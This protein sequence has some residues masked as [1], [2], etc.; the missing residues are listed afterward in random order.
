[1]T[2]ACIATIKGREALLYNTVHS[3]LHQVDELFIMYNYEPRSISWPRKVT[4]VILDNEKGDAAKFYAYCH[5]RELADNW[6]FCDDDLIYPNDYISKSLEFLKEYPNAVL[7]YHARALKKRP[8][9]MFYGSKSRERGYRCLA[10]VKSNHRI[11]PNGTLGTGVMFMKKP[12]VINYDWFMVK[13][14]ADIWLAKFAIEQK[15]EMIVCK[16]NDG[17]IIQQPC[18]GIWDKH[19]N[20]CEIQTKIYN[21]IKNT[22]FTM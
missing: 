1:M 10:E 4:S 12:L 14:M 6:F 22:Q 9:E 3:L 20:D 7:S 16:H 19:V 5:F 17:W 15:K 18:V 2:I 21:E 13:N 11:D 8:I